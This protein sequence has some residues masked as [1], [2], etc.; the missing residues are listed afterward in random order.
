[1][2]YQKYSAL[3][4]EI[5]IYGVCVKTY[6][7]STQRQE[8]TSFCFRTRA[9]NF[10]LELDFTTETLRALFTGIHSQTP[11]GLIKEILKKHQ[12]DT[13]KTLPQNKETKLILYFKVKHPVILFK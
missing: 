1:M 3:I 2:E 6:F 12:K 11:K 8:T 10:D 5:G 4:D 13:K 7:P 9:D